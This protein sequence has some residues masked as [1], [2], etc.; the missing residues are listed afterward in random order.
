MTSNFIALWTITRR[1]ITRVLRIWTQSLIP[2]ILT[3]TLFILI[4]GYSL[5][6]RITDIVGVTYLEFIIPG[7]L[8]MGV[9]MSAYAA[10][11]FSL[12]I[13]KFHGSIQELLVAPVSYWQIIMGLTVGALIRAGLVGLGIILISFLLTP[14]TIHNVFIIIFFVIMTAL[15]FAFAGI[16]TALWADN[17]DHM[18]VF[19]TFLITPLTYLGGV[20]YSITMLPP[21]WQTVARFN[22]ILYMV[23]GFR[24]GFIGVSDIPIIYS[25]LLVLG[26][27]LFFFFLCI[28][29]FK[30]GYKLRN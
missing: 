12:F 22:P 5:G 29:L 17:F 21:V 25:I 15:L 30:I 2:P 4:F 6:S 20:F 13:Q 7:L 8:M 3:S 24:Y 11:S 14:I 28:Y 19:S 1:E 10:T 27:T 26:L 18:S 9:I 16:A 23:D